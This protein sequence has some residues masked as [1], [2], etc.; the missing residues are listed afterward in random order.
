MTEELNTT[1]DL[2]QAPEAPKKN[3]V[4]LIVLIVV[5][6]LLL[7][8]VLVVAGFF[9]FGGPVVGEV[10]EQVQATLTAAPAY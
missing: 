6:V 1:P 10:M 3:R 5:A 9:L 7:C 4:W 8:C 2:N